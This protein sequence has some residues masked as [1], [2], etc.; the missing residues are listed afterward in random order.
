VEGARPRTPAVAAGDTA[1][2]YGAGTGV[3]VLTDAEVATLLDGQDA[4]VLHVVRR[5][6]EL[7]AAGDTVLPASVFLRLPASE[8]DRFI[9]L[10]A[11]VG[12][13]LRVAGMKWIASFPNNRARGLER[14]SGTVILNC[15][16]TG[17]PVAILGGATISARRTAASAALAASLLWGERPAP[18]RVAVVGCGRISFEIVRLLAQIWPGL[19]EVVGFDI[20]P[21][22]G[23]TF[24][25]RCAGA[26]LRVTAAGSLAQL[27]AMGIE[28]LV[29]A[30]TAITPHIETLGPAPPRLVLHVS[31]R[32]LA[33]SVI[34]ACRNVVD[35][36]AHVCRERTSVHLA[37]EQLGHRRFI[38]ASVGELL[39]DPG[40][41]R[42]GDVPVVF[43]PFGLGILDVAL[44]KLVY[45][46]AR[47]LG[48]GGAGARPRR[49]DRSR[50]R[51]GRRA[52]VSEG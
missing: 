8:R 14:A 25:D 2:P 26:G 20:A 7:H 6:Y 34:A 9:A 47:V 11:Y 1:G 30:T 38:D 4:A 17:E 49:R 33:P 42:A 36:L 37:A 46:R 23:D 12:G 51:G 50:G 35:D 18:A 27:L 48:L 15:R 39:R 22:Q 44:G 31:L 10:P 3:M 19:R 28:L 41:V 5:A 43:S 16:T 45:D 52:A 24:R 29:L 21:S 40:A 13:E 32:D